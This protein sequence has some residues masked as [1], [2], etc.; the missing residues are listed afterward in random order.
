MH[1]HNRLLSSLAL[2]SIAPMPPTPQPD[3]LPRAIL[4]AIVSADAGFCE[5]ADAI[6]R[7][8]IGQ[9]RY[10][11]AATRLELAIDRAAEYLDQ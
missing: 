5:A 10:Q 8:I 3:E 2:A 1:H 9:D 7:G 6:H 4:A 11:A